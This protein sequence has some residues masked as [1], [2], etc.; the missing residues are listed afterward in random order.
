MSIRTSKYRTVEEAYVQEMLDRHAGYRKFMTGC[1][2]R[3]VDVFLAWGLRDALH[4]IHKGR[5]NF[6]PRTRDALL[7]ARAAMKELSDA[8]FAA[9]RSLR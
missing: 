3:H 1:R 4:T 5:W 7:D 8:M 6:D 2:G 9:K